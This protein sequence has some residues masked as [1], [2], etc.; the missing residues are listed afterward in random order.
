MDGGCAPYLMGGRKG[1]VCSTCASAA[2]LRFIASSVGTCVALLGPAS[3]VSGS[4]S[5]VVGVG[6]AADCKSVGR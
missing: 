2:S 5:S 4:S 6:I 1:T 3:C